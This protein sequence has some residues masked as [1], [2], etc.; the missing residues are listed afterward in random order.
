MKYLVESLLMRLIAPTNWENNTTKHQPIKFYKKLVC[1]KSKFFERIFP[2]I[3]MMTG[4]FLCGI[5][6]R[7]GCGSGSLYWG[8]RIR[9]TKC[10]QMDP[11]WVQ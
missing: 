4:Q 6:G 9:Q 1:S 2:K 7:T 11:A 8:I 3:D 10:I 5:S